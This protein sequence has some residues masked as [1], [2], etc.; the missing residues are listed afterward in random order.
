MGLD[1]PA[2]ALINGLSMQ[3]LTGSDWL[4]M[5]PLEVVPA[6][7]SAELW[8]DPQLVLFGIT[9]VSSAP[10]VSCRL[11]GCLFSLTRCLTWFPDVNMFGA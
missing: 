10:P 2:G 3:T 1:L 6:L 4:F 5:Q 11:E 7:A 8:M 9:T